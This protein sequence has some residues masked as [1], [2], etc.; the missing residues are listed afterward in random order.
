MQF[1]TEQP[2]N[3]GWTSA[4]YPNQRNL[5]VLI[6]V[7]WLWLIYACEHI[8]L[9]VKRAPIPTIENG[10]HDIELNRTGLV[11]VA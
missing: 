8:D 11:R 5:A 3:L 10:N 9:P 4:R 1:K 2:R 7:F 6:V